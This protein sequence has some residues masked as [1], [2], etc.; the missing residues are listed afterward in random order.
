[1]LSVIVYIL[2]IL[3]IKLFYIQFDIKTWEL[4]IVSFKQKETTM[5]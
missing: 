2:Q 1:M 4:P 3:N 5:I